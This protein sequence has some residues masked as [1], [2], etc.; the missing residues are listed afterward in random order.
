MARHRKPLVI[1][2]VVLAGAVALVALALRLLL[3][4]AAHKARLEAAAASALGLQVEV[5]GPLAI[6]F[7]P[8]L[9]VT[10]Q[11]VQVRNGRAEVASAKQARI[12]VNLLYL[13]GQPLR[14]GK[15]EL[16]QAT[17]ALERDRDGRFNF[18]HA[19][20]DGDP[21]PALDLPD[22]AV[23][24]ATIGYADARFGSRFEARGCR[25]DVRGLRH[26]KGPRSK[27]VRDLSFTADVACEQV[28]KDGFAATD[29]RS[30]VDAKGGVFDLKPLALR[31]FGTPG[32]GQLQ[33]DLSKAVPAYRI[34][35]AL[36]KFPIEEFF[37][38]MSMKPIA[39]GHMDFT[40]DLATQG[41][42]LQELKQGAKG[43]L[44]LRATGL[45]F[46][47]ADLDREFARFESSQSFDLVDVGAVFFAGPLGLLV[48]KGYDFAKLAQGSG[49]H[50]EIR[51]LVSDWTVERGVARAHDVALATRDNRVA[52]QGGLDLVNG[53]FDD[54]TIALVD[55]RGCAKVRQQM[56]G[57]FAAPVVDKPNLLTALAGPAVRLLKKGSEALRGE[58][59]DVFYAG[60]VAAPK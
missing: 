16:R 45:V 29:L 4:T 54:L 44:S 25:V 53:R 7:F 48:T 46:N 38:T 40:A 60:A 36:P 31:L 50:S 6:E 18:E 34:V 2:L 33:A 21:L 13:V 30:A 41:N 19:G 28:R 17:I 42:T 35:Y 56:K 43:R 49:G 37:R 22:L 15:I 3:D 47:G 5:A 1:G 58:H 11:D 20:T 27:L 59:C 12:A 24:D 9:R 8:G 52:V 51:V 23:T 32:S 39:T 26:A 10:L 14:I 57:T 55:A